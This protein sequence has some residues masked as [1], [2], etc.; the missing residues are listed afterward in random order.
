MNNYID[1]RFVPYRSPQRHTERRMRT[2]NRCSATQRV[3]S[4]GIIVSGLRILAAIF[5]L[6]LSTLSGDEKGRNGRRR[7]K[8]KRTVKNLLLYSG[9]AL[10]LWGML[11]VVGNFLEA[12]TLLP[13][14]S[15]ILVFA[16][17]VLI[18]AGVAK[19]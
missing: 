3:R 4:E 18:S 16:A 13:T 19:K 5:L 7:Y 14:W 8:V 10:A 15:L 17:V 11:V 9:I 2:E 1:E 12:V 6:L